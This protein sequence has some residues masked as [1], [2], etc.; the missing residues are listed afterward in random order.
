[1]K[2]Q[3][4]AVLAFCLLACSCGRGDEGPASNPT[5]QSA[6]VPPSV[7]GGGQAIAIEFHSRPD[8]PASG[9]NAFEVTVKEPDGTPIT[10]ATVAVAF[11][12]PAMPSMNMPA[13]RSDAVLTHA[14]D[15]TYR[16]VGQLAMGGTWNVLVTVTRAEQRIGTSKF[17]VVAK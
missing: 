5:T 12:M 3:P 15:G 1:M 10:D 8:P 2:P 7:A 11:S 4:I 17:S 16:G 13:M 9:D 6:Q 14:G